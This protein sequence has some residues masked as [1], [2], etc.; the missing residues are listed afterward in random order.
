[1]KEKVLILAVALWI[2]ASPAGAS[3]PADLPA[4]P[5]AAGLSR[6][7]KA[8][9]LNATAAAAVI[10][11]GIAVWDYGQRSPRFRDE[12]WFE[13]TSNEGGADKLGH[14]YSGYVLSHLF[15]YQYR[16]WGF[17]KEQAIR[18]GVLSSAGLTLL[19]ELGDSFS[20]FGFSYQ[21]ALF[22]VLGA[23][24]GYGMVRFPEVARKVD[25]RVEYDPFRSSTR[26][27]DV[28][29]DYDRLKF[30]AA[31]KLDGFDA[32]RDTPLGSLELHLGYYA[33]GYDEYDELTGQND[34]R[35]RKVYVGVG[36][37]VGKLLKPLWDT[38]LFNYIQLPYTYA[39]YN[40][41]LD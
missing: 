6:E 18:L 29:T 35:R 40:H 15:D 31:V 7:T 1:M 41:R 28:T 37:N 5:P 34:G 25:F 13:R 8:V 16:R 23:A 10:G 33:R 36:L 24:A 32:F 22:S 12:G 39:P 19:V 3:Q 9:L 21:D 17:E 2:A 26:K 4:A 30:L 11:W 14:F 20:E 27:K 38:R